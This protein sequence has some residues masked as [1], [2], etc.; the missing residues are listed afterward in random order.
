M[1]RASLIIGPFMGLRGSLSAGRGVRS[2]DPGYIAQ[3]AKTPFA[4]IAAYETGLQ[5]MLGSRGGGGVELALR[6]AV[7]ETLVDRDLIFSQTVGRNVLAGATTRIGSAN[8]ARLSGAYYDVAANLT[9]VKASFDDTHLLIPYVPDWVLRGDGALHGDLPWFAAW[10]GSRPLRAA[11]G[12]G[13]TYVA[14]R[15]LPYGSRSQ[16]ILTLDGSLTLGFRFIE[17]GLA[18]QNLL[19]ARY[20]LGEYNYASDFHSEPM[21]TL[22]P[23]RHF[24]AG[25]PRTIWL[26]IS[27]NYGAEP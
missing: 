25:A 9:Y 4:S 26:S 14:P 19:D 10:L 5:Y 22:V 8:S 11:L 24:T 23:I 7:F 2:I 1:P 18:V 21:P 6:S 15:P 13:V 3:D 12:T 27:L 17:L 20:A 16:S